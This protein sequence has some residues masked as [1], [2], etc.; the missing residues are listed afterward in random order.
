MKE[1]S[2]EAFAL[3]FY[4]HQI[5]IDMMTEECGELITVLNHWRRARATKEDVAAE[6]AD[7]EIVLT[8]MKMIFGVE[9]VK[10]KRLE[11]LERLKERINQ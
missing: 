1:V 6:I 3:T 8:Q 7:V 9:L 2:V 10:K 5:Q 11:K 4:G